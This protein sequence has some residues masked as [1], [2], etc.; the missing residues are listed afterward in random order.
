MPGASSA[1]WL[2]HNYRYYHEIFS[3][4]QLLAFHYL[5]EDIRKIPEQEYQYAF[6]TVF[7][8]YSFLQFAGI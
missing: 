3:A 5:I 4:R 7:F 8:Y 2:N 1:R 6:I